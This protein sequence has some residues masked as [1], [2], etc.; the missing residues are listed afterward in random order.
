MARETAAQRNAR[1]EAERQARQDAMQADYPTLLLDTLERA[2]RLSFELTVRDAMFVVKDL[3]SRAQ[4]EMTPLYTED[5]QD[6][7]ESLVYD[8]ES[9]EEK[10]AEAERRYQAKQTALAKLTK[11]E[12]E[13]LGL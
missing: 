9:E 2:T 10:R 6:A 3:N 5:S 13:L 4:W 1:Q 8:V 11:E 12:R 7:L